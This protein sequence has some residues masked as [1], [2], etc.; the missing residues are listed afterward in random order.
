MAS[1][2]GTLKDVSSALPVHLDQ[3]VLREG[4]NERRENNH[5]APIHEFASF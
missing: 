5:R 4:E 2:R 3:D 1:Q